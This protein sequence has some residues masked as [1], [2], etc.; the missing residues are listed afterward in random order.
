DVIVGADRTNVGGLGDRGEAY[1]VFGGSGLGG[2][3]VTLNALG[4]SGFTL[5]GF[6]DSALAGSSVAGAGDVNGDGFADVIVGAPLTNAGGTDRGEVYVIFAPLPN[7]YAAGS[8]AGTPAKV[9]VYNAT[10]HRPR[11]ELYPFGMGFT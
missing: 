9:V 4:T 6:E 3:A 10:T 11:A 8:D 7:V 2:T 1:V 5:R